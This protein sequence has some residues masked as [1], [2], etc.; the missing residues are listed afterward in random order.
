MKNW[1]RYLV[2]KLPEFGPPKKPQT[3]MRLLLQLA[4][5][6]ILTQLAQ[7]AILTT[8]VIMMGLLDEINLAAGGLA[9]FLFNILRTMGFGMVIG[10]ANLV[11]KANGANYGAALP[12]NL[13]AGLI[14]ATGSAVLAGV[15]LLLAPK[16]L[17]HLGQDPQIAS[18]TI[19]YLAWMV[20]GIFPAFWFYVYRGLSTGI[21]I[22]APLLWISIV[23]VGVNAGLNWILMNGLF[24][25]PKMGLQGIAAAS[26][27]VFL[28]SFVMMAAVI[29]NRVV[30]NQFTF[31]MERILSA[32]RSLLK[33]GVPTAASYGSE[34][35]FFAVVALLMGALG[36]EALAAHTLVNQVIYIVF[37]IAIGLSHAASIG[38]SEARGQG[39]QARVIRVGK[40]AFVLGG[41]IMTAIAVIYF[42]APSSIIAAITLNSGHQ[43]T[44]VLSLAV[45]LLFIA[46]IL[47]IFD[48][49]QNIGIG[50]LRALDQARIGLVITLIGYWLIGLPSTW[51]FGFHL[52]FGAM[53]IW[54]GL[55]IGIAATACMFV[56]A[57]VFFAIIKPKHLSEQVT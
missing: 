8:D 7:V 45:Q 17:P 2:K 13:F 26:S 20:P 43:P 21:R 34:A 42:V 23:S 16:W 39:K 36:P 48:C 25:A 30:L 44:S 12:E 37:M 38:I 19:D 15:L 49:T 52:N 4:I 57:F 54:I 24:G 9:F 6:L 40:T 3:E 35:G 55:A 28:L 29:H 5:P 47:Q 33:I 14:V 11:A 31:H 18:Q 32:T 22:T 1:M 10:M 51:I 56:I 50:V 46:G 41:A 27:L 53:G